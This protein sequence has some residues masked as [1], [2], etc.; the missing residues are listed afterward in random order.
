MSPTLLERL[1]IPQLRR[2][3]QPP[4][5][6]LYP[7]DRAVTDQRTV[8]YHL[9][10]DADGGGL[11]VVNATACARLTPSG[12][13]IAHELLR[14]QDEDVI[15]QTLVATFSGAEPEQQRQDILNVHKL[16]HE[17]ADPGGRYPVFNLDDPSA[18]AQ[19]ARLLPPIEAT[20]PLVGPDQIAP[21]LERLW[22]AGIPHVTLL[23]P[24]SLDPAALLAAV[25]AATRAGLIC[26]VS[27]RATDFG[28]DPLLDE[29][30]EAGL[31]HLTLAYASHQAAL[32][33]SLYGDGDHVLAE[34]LFAR[35]E[36]LA[37]ADVAQIPLIEAT[38]DG[39]DATL[40]RLLDLGVV[41]VQFFALAEP[42]VSLDGAIPAA[43]MAQMAATVEEAAER[44][45]VLY[46][47]QPPELRQPAV[48]LAEQ[49]R[50]GPRCTS[51]VAI[52]VEPDG[53][54]MPPRGPRRIAGNLLSDP[55]P[56]IWQDAAFKAYRGRIERPTRCLTCPGLAI[57]AADCPR[58][59][60]GWSQA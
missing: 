9:R 31:D 58:E 5:P 55:W 10:V 30:I 20:L 46:Q 56:V 59:P 21:L 28:A 52:H 41:N 40:A 36:A 54:V 44:A 1:L 53:S 23:A 33:D 14:G 39:L 57:C 3:T 22:L 32:H 16:L 29:L 51:D 18:S 15:I 4:A 50:Q 13:L 49:V 45:E 11:L 60:A 12:V 34:A 35:T 17:L 43:A 48:A 37:L 27:G 47:W 19:A 8:R 7:F 6:G 2:P 38:V 42:G 24:P 26:G 25:Q